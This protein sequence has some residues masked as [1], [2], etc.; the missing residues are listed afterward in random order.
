MSLDR[1]DFIKGLGSGLILALANASPA[2]AREMQDLTPINVIIPRNYQFP[3]GAASKDYS[4]RLVNATVGFLKDHYP[5]KVPVWNKPFTEVDFDKRLT[6]IVYWLMVGVNR[7]K[8]IYPVD[9]VWAIAQMMKESYF[10]EFAVSTALAVG[11]CQFIQPTALSYDMLCAGISP[12]HK[13][14]PY[15]RTELANKA[16]EYYQIRNDRRRYRRQNKPKKRFSLTE[17]LEIIQS[18]KVGKHRDAAA[19]HLE[20]LRQVDGYD[21]ARSKARDDFRTY[22]RANVEGRDIFNPKDLAYI[23]NF[24]E[25]FTYKKPV[26]SMVKMLAEGLRARNGNILAATIAYNAGLNSTLGV[27]R[28]KRFGRIPAIEQSTTYLSHIL[29]NHYELLERMG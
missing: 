6:N 13:R 12:N 26:L 21:K 8:N 24:D 11:I 29:V 19:K 15:V 20:Y 16:A 3:S 10:Y 5:N 23:V 28:Y 7:H 27:G 2:E 18:G 17:A 9:P 25:R 22:L 4:K 1:K 14:P